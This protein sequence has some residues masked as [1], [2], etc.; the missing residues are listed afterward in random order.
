MHTLINSAKEGNEEAMVILLKQFVPLII[1]LSTKYSK[2]IDEDCYQ[3]LSIK[4]IIAVNKFDLE[5]FN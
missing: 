1:K 2:N 5:K 4:F 3:E